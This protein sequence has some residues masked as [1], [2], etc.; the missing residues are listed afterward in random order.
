MSEG[1]FREDLYF[2]LNVVPLRIA[3]LRER[4]TDIPLLVAHFVERFADELGV[5]RRWPTES[6]LDRLS[7]HAWPGNVRELENAIKRA[8]VLASGE[9]ITP[10]DI[11]QATGPAHASATSDWAEMARREIVS[12]FE[13]SA[14]AADEDAEAGPYWSFVSRLERAIILEAL[15]HSRGNQIQA[16][17]LLGINRNTLRK[18]ITELGIE[19]SDGS[20]AD[21]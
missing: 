12:R 1:R 18:K 11:D 10:D 2:R 8:L 20:D 6:A 15:E 9:V 14:E 4:R 17:R 7:S 19:P 13:A 5:P 21:S 16:S 3:P